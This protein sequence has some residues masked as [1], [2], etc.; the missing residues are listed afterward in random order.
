[1]TASDATPRCAYCGEGWHRGVCPRV[2]VMH[3]NGSVEF[4]PPDLERGIYDE[5]KG[6]RDAA[7]WLR[8]S[9]EA[10]RQFGR[11]A[12]ELLKHAHHLETTRDMKVKP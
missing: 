8:S 6:F 1:M 11:A 7:A 2:R 3:P 10:T 4:F 9:P 5:V 12:A